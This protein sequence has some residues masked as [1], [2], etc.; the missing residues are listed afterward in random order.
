VSDARLGDL[1]LG[2]GLDEQAR[3]VNWRIRRLLA[4][5]Y[6]SDDAVALGLDPT[7]DIHVAIRLVREGCP[8]ETAVRILSP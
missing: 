3:V 2:D 7:I 4:A 6:G 1:I 5:G 8:P